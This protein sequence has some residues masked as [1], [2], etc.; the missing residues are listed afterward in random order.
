MFPDSQSDERT[1][2][3]C[4]KLTSL[5]A[6]NHH[7]RTDRMNREMAEQSARGGDKLV[8]LLTIFFIPSTFVAV[9]LPIT[10]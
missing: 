6:I 1:A 7:D 3:D 5:E 10:Y 9:M 2:T 4:T 8:A